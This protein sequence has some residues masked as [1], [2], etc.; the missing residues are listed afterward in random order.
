MHSQVYL[1]MFNRPGVICIVIN[2]L[3]MKRT[4][5]YNELSDNINDL[6]IH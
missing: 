6:K 4:C 1:H 2:I 5:Q 3:N